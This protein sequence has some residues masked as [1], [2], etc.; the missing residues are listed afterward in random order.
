MVRLASVNR[1]L[2]PNC[3][4]QAVIHRLRPLT[5]TFL[6]L[7]LTLP[8]RLGLSRSWEW[9]WKIPLQPS[10]DN[11]CFG[12]RHCC[13]EARF[14]F[15]HAS[16]ALARPDRASRCSLCPGA[17]HS[18]PLGYPSSRAASFGLEP[19]IRLSLSPRPDQPVFLGLA[20]HTN[21]CHSD[22]AT[23][24]YK[25]DVEDPSSALDV[26]SD[27]QSCSL[28][29]TMFLFSAQM[30]AFYHLSVRHHPCRTSFHSRA[31]IG[32]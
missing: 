17:P 13:A 28:L 25:A 12:V 9:M 26:A 5:A 1:P 30:C 19:F 15:R 2:S 10:I 14:T 20:C 8:C 32:P 4:F 31:L 6:L 11:S 21:R 29:R 22:R 3:P 27:L 7:G 16:L 24:I 18:S 23:E